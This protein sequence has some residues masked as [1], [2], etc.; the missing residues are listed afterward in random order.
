MIFAFP[1]LCD[2]NKSGGD[3]NQTFLMGICD[4][5]RF[6]ISKTLYIPWSGDKKS[7]FSGQS[8]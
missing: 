6:C 2:V 4:N 8:I 7:D 1:R 5:I 3:G